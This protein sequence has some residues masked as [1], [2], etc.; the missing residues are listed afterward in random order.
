MALKLKYQNGRDEV[1]DEKGNL[2]AFVEDDKLYAVDDKGYS[3]EV[4]PISHRVEII[5]KYTA[6]YA[7]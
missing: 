6:W 5:G 7:R 3:K 4:G 1:I 2:K